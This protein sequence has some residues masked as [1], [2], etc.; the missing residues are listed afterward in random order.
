MRILERKYNPD[1]SAAYLNPATRTII[2]V[3]GEGWNIPLTDGQVSA[4]P[5]VADKGWHSYV[6]LAAADDNGNHKVLMHDGS[7]R[8]PCDNLA[9]NYG[10]TTKRACDFLLSLDVS[11][12]ATIV[13]FSFSYDTTKL[14][15][16]LPYENLRELCSE[17]QL[18]DDEYTR[19]VRDISERYELPVEFVRG[20]GYNQTSLVATKT[21]VYD[22]YWIQ[23]VPRKQLRII[24]LNAG[25][26]KA[27][28]HFRSRDGSWKYDEPREIWAREVTVWDV[29]SFFQKSFVRALTDY[30][31][32]QCAGCKT[33][34]QSHCLSAPWSPADLD[35]ITEMKLHRG[36]FK[37][38]EQQDI[39]DYCVKECEYLTFLVRDLIVSIESFGLKLNRYDGPGAVASAFMK[40]KG[41]KDS[42]P[43]RTI[44]GYDADGI[45]LF[46]LS[47]LPESL[48]LGAYFG[49]RFEIS[50]IGYIGDLY[51]Y[52]INSA[53]PHIIR[54]L[55]CLRHG[56]FVRVSEPVPGRVGVYLAGSVTS[57]R[58]APFPFRTD[59]QGSGSGSAAER[60]AI[61][62]AHGGQRWVWQD[63]L[64]TAR[65]H[66]GADAIPVFDG[67]I[68]EPDGCACNVFADVADL[69]KLRQQYVKDGNGIEKVI[70]L[71]LNSLYGKTAQ[72]I[73]WKISANGEKLPPPYQCFIWAGLITSGCRAM[74]LDAI[75]QPGADVVSIAT[76]GILSRTSISALPAPAEKILGAW[77]ADSVSEGYLFQSGIY[78]Y[79]TSKGK[80]K[81]ATR[82][83]SA[84]EIPA[85]KLI[86]AYM[87]G[88]DKVS[89]DP[90]ESRFVPMKSG[91]L[92][93][94][95]LEYIGQWI[96]SIHDVRFIHTRRLPVIDWDTMDFTGRVSEPHVFADDIV[97][98]AYEPK[99]DW[100]DVIANQ[101]SEDEA[102]Y[103]EI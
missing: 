30:R 18:T 37:P 55:P 44:T 77:E 88:E 64:F 47:G 46:S 53:Y 97:S 54:S 28:H 78:R 14:F 39:T 38:D 24:D 82:G 5:H 17:K 72:S 63:E 9:R 43:V 96:P 93:D 49:G 8:E 15:A 48:A 66:F 98:A 32:G 41:I 36:A 69:Y 40:L 80:E 65:E 50:E 67:W 68:W 57:G 86:G 27:R 20:S 76:D 19:R 6:M 34:P 101:L 102:D 29:F 60:G 58:Y 91:I 35:R 51:S 84:R 103:L 92:R 10:L 59:G 94:G 70:K 61:Y 99:E 79:I 21:T 95:A 62:Y 25:R 52:D 74:I 75:M 2:S 23:Y 89:S 83:F 33:K 73:G 45:P 81:Y 85:D 7:R 31:C 42:L 56:R 16:D 13:G 12:D 87:A 3:D 1:G 26:V 100:E 22:G 11:Q 4:N 71:I 90:G